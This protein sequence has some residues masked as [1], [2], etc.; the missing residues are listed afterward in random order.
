MNHSDILIIGGVIARTSAGARLAKDSSVNLLE[1]ESSLSYHFSELHHTVH[2]HTTTQDHTDQ[3]E[4]SLIRYMPGK[5]VDET[6][7][8]NSVEKFG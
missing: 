7:V 2:H 8:I 6:I 1:T 3:A 4:Y 5:Q